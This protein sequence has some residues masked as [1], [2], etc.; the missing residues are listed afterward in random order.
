V[1]V[2]LIDHGGRMLAQADYEQAPGARTAPRLAGAGE[3][4][5]DIVQLSPDQLKGA[6]GIA[7]GIWEPPG[8][9]LRADRGDRD[10]DNRR[11]ILPVPRNFQRSD[12]AA[13]AHYEG[14]LEHVGCDVISGWAWNASDPNGQ[15]RIRISNDGKPLVTLV[16]DRPRSDLSAAGKGN[17]VHAFALDLPAALK[18]G[19]SHS[20][21]A[22]ADDSEFELPNS[23]QHVTCK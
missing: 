4:W 19:R 20:I 2:H 21:A 18:D 6:T 17:G 12:S 15:S 1:F 13:T 23:P 11:L 5:R 8:T 14:R 10:W 7:F 3:V 22:K 9:F 16:A